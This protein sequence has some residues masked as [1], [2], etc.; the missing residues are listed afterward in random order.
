F[1]ASFLLD[2]YQNI[3]KL[4]WYWGSRGRNIMSEDLSKLENGGGLKEGR[5]CA[6]KARSYILVFT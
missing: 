2:L 1:F 6:L 4:T 3:F 5:A